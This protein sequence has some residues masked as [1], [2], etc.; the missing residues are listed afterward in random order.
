MTKLSGSSDLPKGCGTQRD[1][2]LTSHEYM[3]QLVLGKMTYLDV[4][5]QWTLSLGFG[6]RVSANVWV[7]LAKSHLMLMT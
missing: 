5:Q 7:G 6:N 1:R 3:I 4:S 2:P